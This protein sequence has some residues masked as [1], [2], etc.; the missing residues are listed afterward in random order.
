MPQGRSPG[1]RL[2]HGGT[3]LSLLPLS[4][5]FSGGY[6]SLCR[7]VILNKRLTTLFPHIEGLTA[8]RVALFEDLR[9]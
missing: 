3:P 1:Q 6:G 9:A 2:G 7:Q 8:G 5:Y 4:F